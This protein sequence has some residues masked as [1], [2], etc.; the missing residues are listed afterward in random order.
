M[1]QLFAVIRTHGDAWKVA[2]SMEA[3]DAW[4]EH[5]DFMDHLKKIGFV[6][7]GGPMEDTDEVLLIVR[8]ES[9][10]E[11]AVRLSIDPWA[12][13]DLLRTT[14]IAPWTLRLGSLPQE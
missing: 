6:I 2:Q 12:R 10:A 7:L 8:A 5:A 4:P 13:K 9:P 1:K 3:Q 11:I 14:R